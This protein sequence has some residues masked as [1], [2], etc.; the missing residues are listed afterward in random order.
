MSPQRPPVVME[1]VTDAGEVAKAQVQRQSF[2]RNAAWLQQHISEVYSQHRGKCIC[3]AGQE[4]FVATTAREA[5]ALAEAA[6]PE[7]EGRFTRYIPREK[8][9]RVYAVRR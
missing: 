6:H 9:A 3:V 2:D 5:M 1:E 7:D 8:V 4:L